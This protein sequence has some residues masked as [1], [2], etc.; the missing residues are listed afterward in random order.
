MNNPLY[1]VAS[2]IALVPFIVI[3][4]VFL[5]GMAYFCIVLVPSFIERLFEKK[6]KE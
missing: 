1:V 6:E 3:G 4:M 5:M 2:I